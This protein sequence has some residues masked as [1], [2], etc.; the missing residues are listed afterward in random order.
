MKVLEN[1]L[2]VGYSVY[3]LT[4]PLPRGGGGRADAPKGFASI[5]LEQN[6]LG[7]SKFA[8]CNFNNIDVGGYNQI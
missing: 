1:H 8:Y 3:W 4:L 7:T 2:F 5:T 6:N